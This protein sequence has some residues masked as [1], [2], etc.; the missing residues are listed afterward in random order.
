MFLEKLLWFIVNIFLICYRYKHTKS[1][2]LWKIGVEDEGTRSICNYMAKTKTAEVLD[3]M[4]NEITKL[5]F[6]FF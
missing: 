4:D 3:L 5:G 2:K 1:I 6:Y